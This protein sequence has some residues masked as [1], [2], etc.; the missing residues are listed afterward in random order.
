MS[1]WI[2]RSTNGNSPWKPLTTI[3]HTAHTG[4]A[5]RSSGWS[6]PGSMNDHANIAPAATT[7]P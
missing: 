1:T 7:R 2:G 6:L 5:R 4:S 3:D